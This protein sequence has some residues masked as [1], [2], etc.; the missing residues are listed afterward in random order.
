VKKID[1]TKTLDDAGIRL[2]NVVSDISGMSATEIISGLVEEKSM[3]E[4]QNFY[5]FVTLIKTLA[6]TGVVFVAIWILKS[7][8]K[9]YINK[10]QTTVEL[11]LETF[12]SQEQVI[13]HELE[14]IHEII[15]KYHQ[16]QY[17]LNIKFKKSHGIS[18]SLFTSYE[19]I[20]QSEFQRNDEMLKTL[21][22]LVNQ[23]PKPSLKGIQTINELINF[24]KKRGEHHQKVVTVAHHLAPSFN[25]WLKQTHQQLTK[26]HHTQ[27]VLRS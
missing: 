19:T 10:T 25:A 6:V 12:E 8:N 13:S 20:T 7:I 14:M 23:Y 27:T 15:T 24:T 2:G 26:Q 9:S 4:S 21:I 22:D 5:S 18:N 16:E 11:A 1:Y 3:D 17:A